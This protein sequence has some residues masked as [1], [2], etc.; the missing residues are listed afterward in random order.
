[1]LQ[2][3]DCTSL[4]AYCRDIRDSGYTHITY[5]QLNR[6]MTGAGKP[7]KCLVRD[8]CKYSELALCDVITPQEFGSLLNCTRIDCPYRDTTSTTEMRSRHA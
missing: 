2:L 6:A 1:M 8:L 3:Q 5:G 4:N 7:T